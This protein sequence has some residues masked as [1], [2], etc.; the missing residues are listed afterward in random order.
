MGEFEAVYKTGLLVQAA[1]VTGQVDDGV[2]SLERF[3]GHDVCILTFF[4]EL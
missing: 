1:E 2:L 4:I 3:I